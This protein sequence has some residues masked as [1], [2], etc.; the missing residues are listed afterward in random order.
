MARIAVAGFQHETNCFATPATDFAYFTSHRD[1]PPLVRG[2]DVLSWLGQTSFALSGFLR[3]MLPEHEIVPLLWTSGGAGGL[4]TAEAFERI[5]G[6]AGGASIRSNPRGR[7][8]PRPSRRD[9]ERGIRG[10]G[11]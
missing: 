5:A 2:D 6:E 10:L 4:V 3:S 1:R 9:G 8:L 11:R 7:G